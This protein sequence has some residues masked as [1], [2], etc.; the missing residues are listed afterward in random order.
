[1]SDRSLA[2]N[3][4]IGQAAV[5]LNIS[6]SLVKYLYICGQIFT[7]IQSKKRKFLI[8]IGGCTQV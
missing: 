1:M 7:S 5:Y 8:S 6:F 4:R 3:E 2:K